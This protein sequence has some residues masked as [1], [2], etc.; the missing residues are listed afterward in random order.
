LPGLQSGAESRSINKNWGNS[1]GTLC[2]NA[3]ERR[4]SRGEGKA[5]T[6]LAEAERAR[7][8]AHDCSEKLAASCAAIAL[9]REQV[10]RDYMHREVMREVEQ[11]LTEAIDRLADRLD[12]L[13]E[14]RE[15]G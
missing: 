7:K 15:I 10:A 13:L 3:L 11:R 9:Y 8:I 1:N 5:E 6:A 2:R 12:R 4:I 14:R